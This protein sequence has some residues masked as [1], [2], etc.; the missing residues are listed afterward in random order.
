MVSIHLPLFYLLGK[1]NKM[2]LEQKEKCVKHCFFHL[3]WIYL[4]IQTGNYLI[5]VLNAMRSNISW[6]QSPVK[7]FIKIKPGV[8][9]SQSKRCVSIFKKVSDCVSE[10]EH[11]RKKN[12]WRDKNGS[13]IL[14]KNH[15]KV[16][17]K[18]GSKKAGKEMV[19]EY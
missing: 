5:N 12:P 10:G 11:F 4:L 18:T 6:K 9:E 3:Y 13:R 15:N 19:S 16:Y 2:C 1:A 17:E 7:G 8:L 14:M